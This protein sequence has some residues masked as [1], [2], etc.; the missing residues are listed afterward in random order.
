MPPALQQATADLGLRWD[1]WTITASLGQCLVGSWFLSPVGP[2]AHM[3]LSVP[4]KSPFPQSWV[5]SGGSMVVWMVT[6]S[7]R[8]YAIPRS[9]ASRVPAPTA[10]HCWPV[11]PQETLRYSSVSVSVGS[12]GPGTQGMFE[13]PECLWRVL[14]LILNAIL[15]ILPSC[16]VSPLPLD[17]GYLLTVAAL[18]WSCHCH[19]LPLI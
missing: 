17:E 10:V 3:V 19:H 16:W 18:Q 9:T 5:S 15:P 7:Q 6:S 4:S 1:S 8:A 2:G 13:P 14:C 12:L 11:P